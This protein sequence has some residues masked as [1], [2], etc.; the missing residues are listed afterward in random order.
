VAGNGNGGLYLVPG[1]LFP[2]VAGAWSHWAKWLLTR[3]ELLKEWAIYVDQVAMALALAREGIDTFDL[4]VRWNLP[5]HVPSIIPVDPSVPAVIPYHQQVDPAGRILATGIAA[6]D[7]RINEANAALSDIWRE[8]FPN[9]T[10]WEWRYLTNPELGSGV[11]SRGKP[12]E[13]KRALPTALLDVLH[14]ESALDVG[15]GDGEATRG[16]TIKNCVGLDLSAEAVRRARSGRPDGDYRVG[17]LADYSIQADFTMCLD[18]LIHQADAAT[19][20]ALVGR[21]LR[22]STCALV[23]SGYEHPFQVTF[24]TVHFHE[25]LSTTIMRFDPEAEIYPLREEH[26]MVTLLVLKGPPNRHFNDFR[27]E[28]LIE[29]ISHHSNLPWLVQVPNVYARELSSG[30]IAQEAHREFVG[31]LW[32]EIGALQ[33]NFMIRQGLRPDMRLLDLGCGCLRGGVRFLQYLERGNYYGIDSNA[34]L[35]RAAW[36]IELP[37]AGLEGCIARKNLLLNCDFEAWRFGVSFDTSR[38]AFFCDV[39][40]LPFGL[41]RRRAAL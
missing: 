1:A 20:H 17:T 21:L 22:S 26:P 32:D 40:P 10:F 29:L 38:R 7:G 35:L 16:L 33:L 30:E 28:K 13:D 34:S 39:F 27:A 3:R 25:P 4:D 19:Y 37:R 11:G 2:D 24:S 18:V 14:P 23:V 9:A 6:I 31:G 15:C 8:D 5:I 36:E 12:L 41:A